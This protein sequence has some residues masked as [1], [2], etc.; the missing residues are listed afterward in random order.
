MRQAFRGA[1]NAEIAR[2]MGKSEPAIGNYI[3]GRVTLPVVMEVS[4]LT[5]CSVDWLLTGKGEK[6][7]DFD[8]QISIDELFNTR[9][10]GLVREE[11]I[12]GAVAVK[13]I[14]G[15]DVDYA[16]LNANFIKTTQELLLEISKRIREAIKVRDEKRNKEYEKSMLENES[17]IET[18]LQEI[19]RGEMPQLHGFL[20]YHRFFTQLFISVRDRTRYKVN[21]LINNL[22]EK[23]YLSQSEFVARD[24]D[25]DQ[26]LVKD[27]LIYLDEIKERE[28]MIAE[29]Q[30]KIKQENILRQLIKEIVREELSK[31]SEP[32]KTMTFPFD[33]GSKKEKKE[34]K[35]A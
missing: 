35:A 12:R 24:F 21:W 27:F 32:H 3:D 17:W 30:S 16:L 6:N 5:G 9:I 26:E 14:E 33:V 31:P 29:S 13:S 20:D 34:N 25:Q 4:K 1:N 22:G 15:N 19:E 28:A 10:K 2:Q 7:V 23:T 18:A 8:K 11:I